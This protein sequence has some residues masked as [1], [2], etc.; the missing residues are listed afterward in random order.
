MNRR[1]SPEGTLERVSPLLPGLLFLSAGLAL[2]V[3]KSSPS[4]F[5]VFLSTGP[6]ILLV[7]SGVVV[8][9][10]TVPTDYHIRILGW[11]LLGF[12]S[13]SVITGV[14]VVNPATNIDSLSSVI[15]G[16][17]IGSLTGLLGGFH[18]ARAIKRGRVAAAQRSDVADAQAES[19]QLEHVTHLLR[20]DISN[21]LLVIQGHTELLVEEC[22]GEACDH[23]RKI[24][25]QSEN[26]DELLENVQAYLQSLDSAGTLQRKNLA[27][28]LSKEVRGLQQTYP[29][30]R[31]EQ[32]IPEDFWVQADDL[33]GAVFRNVLRNAVVHNH[34]ETPE[35]SV[36]V[37]RLPDETVVD[38]TDN[39]PGIPQDLRS[40]LF[41][42]PN[43]GSHGFG[44]YL[45][46]TLVERY[47]GS[48]S[49]DSE[50]GSGTTIGIRFP[51]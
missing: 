26:I 3:W 44:L 16:L 46:K 39:G 31:V 6:S 14:L 21:N 47:D 42:V 50:C 32:D 27:T 40:D 2:L 15:A 49:V 18:E 7:A 20:H 11:G 9:R 48:I 28:V 4:V 13:I 51:N 24:Q 23:A 1:L 25:T 30:V 36:T 19:S 37:R 8:Y 33:L 38:I 12:A 35:L 5:D 29:E 43:D 10:S 34:R 22:E 41:E 17:G 45:V